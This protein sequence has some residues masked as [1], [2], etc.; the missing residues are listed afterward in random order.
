MMRLDK[1]LSERLGIPRG[2]SRKLAAKGRVTVNGVLTKK[3]DTQIEEATAEVAVDGRPLAGAYQKYVY[4]M[5]NKPEGVVS[6][7]QDKRDTTVV[8][9][10]GD[11]Y[12]RRELFPA[13]RLDKTSTGFVLLTDDGALA[14]DILAP[15][16]HVDKQYLVTLDTPLTEE[17]RRGFAAGVTLADGE[18]LAPAEAEP[19]GDDPCTVRVTLHQGVYHQIKRMFGVY[20]AGVNT[21][22]RLSI[23]GV[24][25]DET[26]APG[27]YRELTEEER[28]QLQN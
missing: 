2:E 6:A 12:P 5:L 24:A 15:A 25:L 17:M 1:Y 10:I 13:G 22:H 4:L 8:D 23:G 16:H 27:E 7:A 20:D 3:A 21:L 11:A 18:H 14:H 9:L 19:A 26:L 28:K